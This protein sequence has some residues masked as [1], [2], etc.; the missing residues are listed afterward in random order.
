MAS[1]SK[2]LRGLDGFRWRFSAL[3]M[4]LMKSRAN[5]SKPQNRLAWEAQAV[6]QGGSMSLTFSFAWAL[7]LVYER[8]VLAMPWPARQFLLSQF[9]DEFAAQRAVVRVTQVLRPH[10]AEHSID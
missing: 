4:T 8:I 5:K 6:G 9:P 2:A 10:R 1:G 7:F 3:L